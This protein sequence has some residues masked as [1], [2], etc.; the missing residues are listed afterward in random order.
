MDKHTPGPWN[1]APILSASESDRGWL[2][3]V[4]GARIADVWP[5][6]DKRG[7][8]SLEAE[9]NCRLIAAAPDLLASLRECCDYLSWGIPESAVGGDDEAIRLTRR[10]SEAIRKAEGRN[11]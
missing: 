7:N 5:M 1:Y 2:V 6:N 4:T 11:E 3:A 10:A 9:A 8:Y